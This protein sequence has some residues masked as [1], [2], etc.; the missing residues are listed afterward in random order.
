MLCRRGSFARGCARSTN[1]ASRC[2]G[3]SR[4][5]VIWCCGGPYLF[6]GAGTGKAPPRTVRAP[7]CQRS[8]PGVS[9]RKRHFRCCR[10]QHP[11]CGSVAQRLG[12]GSART[13][14]RCSP[15]TRPSVYPIPNTTSSSWPPLGNVGLRTPVCSA[16]YRT[17]LLLLTIHC[18]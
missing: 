13:G 4:E 11:V 6:L 18:Y 5:C 2:G 8:R 9:C 14:A 16:R 17:A 7:G 12:P 15:P 3:H 1:T 10:N